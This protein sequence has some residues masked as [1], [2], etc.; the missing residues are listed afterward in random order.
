MTDVPKVTLVTGA[1]GL[2]GNNVV[3]LLR[4]RGEQVRVLVRP[5]SAR[6]P[7]KDLDLQI[8][9][10]DVRDEAAVLRACEGCS[11]VIHCAGHVHI[12]WSDRP[13]FEAVNVTGTRNVA[14][15]CLH[16][17]VRMVH[18]SSTDVFGRCSLKHPTTEETPFATGPCP[19][20]V[21]T[22]RQAEVVV[23]QTV[24]EG[25]DAVIVNPAF[26]LGP[27]DWH[28]S[29][30]KVLLAV[31]AGRAVLA[32]RGW[33]SLCDVRDVAQ[34]IVAARDRGRT[35]RRYILAGRTME[36]IEAFRIFAATCGVRPPLARTGPMML[37]I[38]GWSGDFLARVTGRE[39]DINSAAVAMAWLKKNYSSARA[40]AELG[41]HIRPAEET[42]HD[43]WR[44]FQSYALAP[45]P[46]R[47]T[48]EGARYR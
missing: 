5:N 3:R 20:Y 27:W 42:S 38:G 32:P 37:K 14:A 36:W 17:G 19:P 35:G 34:G 45:A 28:P 26:M 21:E 44:W 22:K 16:Y 25:L 1:T 29:S 7:L 8:S 40:E 47:L 43:A 13:L 4:D 41:Y 24:S 33:L 11:A 31:A 18:I 46:G 23:S 15:A 30:G 48:R 39:P 9:E 2:V 12:G 6:R 10:G